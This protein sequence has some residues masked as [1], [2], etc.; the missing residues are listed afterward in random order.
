[1]GQDI[2]IADIEKEGVFVNA[3]DSICD[4]PY[5]SQTNKEDTHVR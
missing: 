4:I 5:R 1:M 2:A 3:L